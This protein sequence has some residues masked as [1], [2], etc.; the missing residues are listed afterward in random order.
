MVKK[1]SLLV[2]LLTVC[3]ALSGCGGSSKGEESEPSIPSYQVYLDIDF[4]GNLL[5]D[6]YDVD[7]C[8]D[9]EKLDTIPHGTYYT[10]ML[11]SVEEGSHT[12][13]FHKNGD[14]SVKGDYE[15]KV[16]SDTTF[17]CK[18]HAKGSEVKIDG[19]QTSDSI[20]GNA[21]QMLD[22]V[23]MNLEEAKESLTQQGFVNVTSE[24]K[25]DVI[26]VDSNWTVVSQNIEAGTECDKNSE[27]I[28]TCEHNSEEKPAAEDNAGEAKADIAVGD[29][30]E[31]AK[32]DTSKTEEVSKSIYNLAYK[33]ENNEYAVYYLIDTDDSQVC[34]FSTNDTSILKGSYT[35]DLND[36]IDV[37]YD[38]ENHELI[39]YKE[40]GNDEA[41]L[42][43]P[44][45]DADFEYAN[46]LRKTTVEEAEEALNKLTGNSGSEETT[47]KKAS[48]EEAVEEEKD[49]DIEKEES[50][51]EEKIEEQQEVTAKNEEE[52]SNSVYD[53]AYKT[54]NDEYAV[55][56]LIDTDDHQVCTFS[57][58]DTSILKRSYTGDLDDRIDVAYDEENHELIKYK[59]KGND[60]AVLISST[61]NLDF[62]Y[63]NEFRK[64]TVE[65]AEEALNKLTGN[66]GSEESAVKKA[67]AEEE[68]DSDIEK[69]ES[70]KE[71][72]KI[73]EESKASE[74]PS[75]TASD[76]EIS[77]QTG[78]G[79]ASTDIVILGNDEGATVTIKVPDVGVT[80]EDLFYLFDEHIVNVS[81]KDIT[82][83]SGNPCV[84]LNVTG[85][86][87]GTTDV[88]VAVEEEYE[89]LGDD[90]TVVS[91][92]VKKLDST[93]GRVVYYTPT[94]EK[95]HFSA[96]CAGD[97]ARATTLHDATS[98]EME[99]C[100]KCAQ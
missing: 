70:K 100:G 78:Y 30:A 15:V 68:K 37:A 25:D 61:S 46:E 42:I 66:S 82:D 6:K 91:I 3:L 26:F 1:M 67:S 58:G 32:E 52:E 12:I 13:L 60:E 11:E 65:E 36:R 50:K 16:K 96:E 89:K 71:E 77:W 9:E 57:T 38:E 43:T 5:F 97:N 4:E 84:E 27:I 90:A 31:E 76:L 19:V 21:I 79:H 74:I 73:E 35:G 47:V 40:K 48:A 28:L 45:S 64:T 29:T 10:K 92:P 81:E 2:L 95:Y 72:E 24:A 54:E 83:Y 44:A 33:T 85:V 41:V 53:L 20:E 14:E 51:K 17:K 22:T 23:G 87:E 63:T 39:K 34:T 8:F 86:A 80:T 7:V 18:I 75:M 62:E 49:F 94:G 88:L 69:E 59:E 98:L 99:P 93:E 56:Y 55:Y